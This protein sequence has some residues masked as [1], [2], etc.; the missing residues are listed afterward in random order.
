MILQETIKNYLPEKKHFLFLSVCWICVHIIV[1]LAY[2]ITIKGEATKYL[3]EAG[4]V[5]ASQPLT[6]SKYVFYYA[7]IL[8]LA[9][10]KKIGIGI[11]GAYI[12]QVGM[13][14]ISS[15]LFYLFIKNR[16]QNTY[17][18]LTGTFILLICFPFQ[19]WASFL[20]TESFFCS[21]L[22]ILVYLLFHEKIKWKI[23]ALAVLLVVVF[24]RPTG[25]L[26]APVLLVSYLP[27]IIQKKYKLSYVALTVLAGVLL[28]PVLNWMMKGGGDFNFM[29]PFTEGHIICGVPGGNP[30]PSLSL[31][32]NGNTIGG[33]LY[34]AYHNFSYFFT[35]GCKKLLYYFG[36]MRPY[37][38]IGH[39][40]YLASFFVPLYIFTMS[41][42]RILYG[43]DKALFW[44][45]VSWIGLFA[46]AVFFSCDEWSNRFIIPSI[47][48][49]II[50]A[51]ANFYSYPKKSTN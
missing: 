22:L 2:G 25:I 9:F 40:I 29:L 30:L 4:N 33:L 20:Y 47:P 26:L 36:M 38:S 28:I 17:A 21:L 5:L 34:F 45:C 37:Y 51:L 49:M 44:F 19:K 50:L 27:F 31:P 35:S 48:I 3:S 43:K 14:G 13:N 46:G 39:N 15:V 32:E 16:F 42:A 10:A 1:L 18:A 11:A 7:Y 6:H 12:I 8:L 41:G 24:T 23:T